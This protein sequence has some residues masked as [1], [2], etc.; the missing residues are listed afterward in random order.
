LPSDS[1]QIADGFDGRHVARLASRT[2]ES[3]FRSAYKDEYPEEAQATAFFTRTTLQRAVAALRVGPGKVVADLGCGHGGP[4]LWAIQQSGAK[5][6]GIDLSAAGITLAQQRAAAAGLS[7]RARFQ[8]GDIAATGL[9]DGSCDAAM[10]L[11]V[12]LFTPDKEAALRE[13]ARIL[14]KGGA[15]AF[16]TWEQTGYSERLRSQQTADYRPLLEAAGLTVEVYEEPPN[17]QIQHRALGEGIIAAE[18]A[19]AE[20]MGVEAAA[21]YSATARG[22]L[23]DIPLRRYVF[24][25]TRRQ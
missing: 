1:R 20:E 16:T 2:L 4:G 14:R 9:A 10:S 15:F 5:L 3:I 23:A 21:R 13:I 24:G 19:L 11:D 6:I 22:N 25:V 17:W 8:V 12:L 18:A 7:E